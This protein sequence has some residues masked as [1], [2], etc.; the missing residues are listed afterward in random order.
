MKSAAGGSK[1]NPR[2]IKIAAQKSVMQPISVMEIP[3][4]AKSPAKKISAAL[5]GISQSKAMAVKTIATFISK[6]PINKTSPLPI[7]R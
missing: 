6:N 1:K 2:I 5:A 4:L 7:S 3:A